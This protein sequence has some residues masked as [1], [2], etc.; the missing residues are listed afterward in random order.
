MRKQTLRQKIL[1]D[2][3]EIV[4]RNRETEQLLPKEETLSARQIAKCVEV[5]K[6]TFG[7]IKR[8]ICVK[9]NHMLFQEIVPQVLKRVAQL[10]FEKEH[11]HFCAAF[12]IPTAPLAFVES[13]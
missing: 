2:K 12:C 3:A 11:L 1:L 9:Y 4:A 8:S 13:Q 6:T 10:T 5:F 7:R